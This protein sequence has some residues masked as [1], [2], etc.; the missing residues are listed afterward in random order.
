MSEAKH[1]A[2]TAIEIGLM[3]LGDRLRDPVTGSLRSEAERHRSIVEQAVL[4]EQMGFHSVHVG[5]HH[6]ND[7]MVSAPPVL[8]AA[9]GERTEKLV[10]ST[11]VTLMATLDP[12]RAAEDYATVDVLS[13]GRAE[14]VAGRGSFFQKTFPAFGLDAADSAELFAENVELLA[15]LLSEEDVVWEGKFRSP[16]HGVTIR[17]RPVGDLPMWVA[18]GS[19]R[20]TVEL[21]ARLGAP[22]MLPSVFAPPD[23]FVAIVE[24][25]REQWDAAGHEGDPVVGACCHCHVAPTTGEARSQFAPWYEHYW[26]WVQALIVDFTPHAKALPFDLDTL[27]AGPAIVGSPAE[28][29]DRVGQWAELLGLSR[30]LFMFDLGGIPDAELFST[31]EL[32]GQEVVPQLG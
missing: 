17:P 11:G 19:S 21:A 1:G 26:Q 3:S 27:Y 23:Q 28:I 31:V 13:G 14:I 8:L 4:A 24:F 9:V 18:G 7:Y 5:E 2:K 6:L 25:Y 30:H 29:V 10:L 20:R 15:R 22:L 16:L 12:L 32:F